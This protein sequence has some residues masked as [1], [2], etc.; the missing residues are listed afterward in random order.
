MFTNKTTVF[1]IHNVHFLA[2]LILRDK[3]ITPKTPTSA[4][5]P[6][7]PPTL[8]PRSFTTNSINTTVNTTT[9]NSSPRHTQTQRFT[10]ATTPSTPSLPAKLSPRHSHTAVEDE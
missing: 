7:P 3:Q 10:T 1:V 6:L 2:D 8:T 4:P 9:P 5:Y